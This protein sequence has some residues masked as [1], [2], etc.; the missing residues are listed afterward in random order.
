MLE[1]RVSENM[2][3]LSLLYLNCLL[4]VLNLLDKVG[5]NTVLTPLCV[6][7]LI[8]FCA[9]SS[10][11]PYFLVKV[12]G[13]ILDFLAEEETEDICTLDL[14]SSRNALSSKVVETSLNTLFSMLCATEMEWILETLTDIRECSLS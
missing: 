1:M 7:F 12:L 3:D 10:P 8:V 14:M 13:S 9:T 4:L 2:L 11:I 6:V 5:C